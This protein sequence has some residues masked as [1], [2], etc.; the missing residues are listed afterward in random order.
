MIGKV[1]TQLMKAYFAYLF[2]PKLEWCFTDE[3][4]VFGSEFLGFSEVAEENYKK[5]CVNDAEQCKIDILG[6]VKESLF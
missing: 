2:Q 1:K 5:N 4:F 6:P 3:F